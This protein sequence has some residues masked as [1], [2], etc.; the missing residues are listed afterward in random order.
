MTARRN[1]LLLVLVVLL[2]VA[3]LVGGYLSWRAHTDRTEAAD[4]QLRYGEVVAAATAHAE[5]L[6][7]LRHDDPSTFEAAQA[8]AAEELRV[9]YEPDGAVVGPVRRDR[10]VLEGEVTWAGVVDAGTDE[11]TALVATTGTLTSRNTDGEPLDRRLRFRVELVL[12]DGEWRAQ[13]VELVA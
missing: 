2:L 9:D 5:A 10:T 7:N 11:A 1:L 8:G 12:E 13:A 6:V 3:A 4:Q